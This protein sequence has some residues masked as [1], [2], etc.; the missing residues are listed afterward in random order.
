MGMGQQPLNIVFQKTALYSL[1]SPQTHGHLPASAPGCMPLGQVPKPIIF[2]RQ[3]LI[4]AQAGLEF[5][6]ICFQSAGKVGLYYVAFC[7]QK[8]RLHTC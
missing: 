8:L 7:G 3:P 1:V 5:S 4:E 2:L 6:L